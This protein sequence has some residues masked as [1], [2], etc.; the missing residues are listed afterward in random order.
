[1]IRIFDTRVGDYEG[2]FSVIAI[3]SST[4][5]EID[6]TFNGVDGQSIWKQHQL[7]VSVTV[8]SS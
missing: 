3:P 4:T 1:V 5:F 6:V 2:T 7:R 8:S